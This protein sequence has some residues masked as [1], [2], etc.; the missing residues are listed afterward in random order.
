MTASRAWA[1]TTRRDRLADKRE[2]TCFPVPVA[3]GDLVFSARGLYDV[4][5]TLS[6]D[7]RVVGNDLN[8]D[9]RRL[10]MITGANQGGKST[11]L[12][13]RSSSRDEEREQRIIMERLRPSGTGTTGRLDMRSSRL[14]PISGRASSLGP[15][16]KEDTAG[17]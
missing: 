1:R 9:N 2:P 8:A 4:C 3:P 7:A 17:R 16:G 10:V 14:P 15:D 13:T 12:P 6:I 11:F 5:L